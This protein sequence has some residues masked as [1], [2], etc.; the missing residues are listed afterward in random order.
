MSKSDKIFYPVLGFF[1]ILSA[2]ALYHLTL[3][4]GLPVSVQ[5]TPA[6]MI[7][8]DNITKSSSGQ[9]NHLHLQTVD[10]YR[11]KDLNYLN[12][13]VELKKIGETVTLG[14]DNEVFSK[15]NLVPRYSRSFIYL[16]ILLSLGFF[17]IAGLVWAKSRKSSDK[18]FAITSLLFG[19]IIAMGWPGMRLPGI[20]ALP[21]VI[22]YFAAYPQ[23]FL[24]FLFFSYQFPSHTV[25]MKRLRIL[26]AALLG[27]GFILS[28]ILLVLFLNKYITFTPDSIQ[29]YYAFYPFFRAFIILSFFFSIAA[30]VRNLI[31]DPNPV[32]RHKVQWVLWGVLWGSFPFLFLWN[33]PQIFKIEPLI[34]EKI[35]IVFL[36]VIP[37]SV[38]IAILKFRLFDIEIVLSRSLVYSLVIGSLLLLYTFIVGGV[39][40]I[41]HNQ[42]SLYR[43]PVVSL[44][45][46]VSIALL[47][48]PLRASVQKRVDKTFFRIR[49]DR[50][51]ILQEFMQD[52]KRQPSKETLLISLNKF[53]QKAVPLQNTLLIINNSET[54]T[55]LAG[56]SRQIKNIQ[57]WLLEN[58]PKL[59]EEIIL[60]SRYSQNIEAQ[61]N[62]P[63][64]KISS[65]WILV[66]PLRKNALWFVGEKKAGTRF[67][68]EDLDLVQQMVQATFLEL[69]KLEYLEISVQERLQKEQAQKVGRW[70]KLLLSE[71]AHDLRAPLNTILWKLKNFQM[72]LSEEN[73]AESNTM[74]EIRNHIFHLQKFIESLL[75]F[76]YFEEGRGKLELEKLTLSS[77]IEKSLIHL[78]G[79]ISQKYISIQVHCS[80]DIRMITHE[81][82]FQEILSNVIQNA[83]KYSPEK[84]NISIECKMIT[85]KRTRGTKIIVCDEGIGISPE[86]LEKIYE[87]FSHYKPS[88]GIKKGFHLGLYI[89]QEFLH[90]LGGDIRIS[91][92]VGKG[93]TVEL[94]FPEQD[95]YITSKFQGEV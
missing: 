28:S 42:F 84:S 90:I 30:M 78:K 66:I 27:T 51:Q 81:T 3:R 41:F 57:K 6:G 68:K 67:W 48:N 5:A 62:L 37:I 63:M 61:I 7:V 54:W 10:N 18:Y 40:F 9:I 50:F 73:S 11:V 29:K 36:L 80:P 65:P 86:N 32:N 39:S 56:D 79:M 44:I 25:S 88:A 13:I 92:Q 22:L 47:F 35:Y 19:F 31:K 55:V 94:F 38:A 89:V 74:E 91:S 64:M 75:H 95:N 82:L 87:P 15:L 34:P 49:Y 26:E 77:E 59:P 8:P 45:S 2:L 85:Q 17:I 14:F 43:F 60:N 21:M 4:P 33:L 70:R 20:I 72:D 1:I 76:S 93:T 46:A 53:F 24:S 69:E 83:I 16:N 71:V 52:L 58:Q 23:A 12:E